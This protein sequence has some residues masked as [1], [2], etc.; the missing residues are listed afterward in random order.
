MVEAY[1]LIVDDEKEFLEGISERLRNR[2]F[3]VDT[4]TSGDEALQKIQGRIYD[5]V[6]LDLKMPG[7]DGLATLRQALAKKPDL[8]IILLTGYATVQSGIEAIREGALDFLEKPVDLDTLVAKIC[9]G[10]ERRLEL[11]AQSRED[12]V[13]E[14][15]K[16]YGW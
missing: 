10:K 14:A 1:V 7:L 5:A 12:A 13:R 16:R 6:V 11:D 3:V 8:Q 2:N 15:L 4:A 9:Q